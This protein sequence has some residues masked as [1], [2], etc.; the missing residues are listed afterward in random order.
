MK[1]YNVIMLNQIQPNCNI[2]SESSRKFVL[3]REMSSKNYEKKMKM[4]KPILI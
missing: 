3:F 1:L 4:R 2:Q